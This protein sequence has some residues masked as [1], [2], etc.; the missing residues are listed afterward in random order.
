MSLSQ[1]RK[2]KKLF[3]LPAISPLISVVLSTLLAFVTK[4]DRHGVRTIQRVKGG[5]NPSSASQLQFNGPFAGESAKIG[6]VCAIV[7]L[8]VSLII[9]L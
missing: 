9:C 8:A 1:G 2:N 5:L 4:A 6:F 3:W 7:A